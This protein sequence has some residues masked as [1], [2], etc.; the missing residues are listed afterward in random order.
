MISWQRICTTGTTSLWRSL[1]QDSSRC[2]NSRACWVC[3]GWTRTLPATWTK[4][5]SP[6]TWTGWDDHDDAEDTHVYRGTGSDSALG[7][8]KANISNAFQ[9]YV[10]VGPLLWHC[11][12]YF[13]I[14]YCMLGEEQGELGQSWVWSY[15]RCHI[16]SS[17][18]YF[19]S[20]VSHS[21]CLAFTG[22]AGPW[23]QICLCMVCLA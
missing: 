17:L 13:D 10:N 9:V 14:L 5:S 20:F 8:Y 12:F 23:S 21:V 2:S 1:R 3:G 6:S 18:Y 22:A 16:L 4:S 7:W 19:V 15:C 11:D